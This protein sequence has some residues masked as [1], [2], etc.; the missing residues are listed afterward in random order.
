MQQI[1]RFLDS[2]A[3]RLGER[4]LLVL[5]IHLDEVVVEEALNVT[6]FAKGFQSRGVL[7]DG[8]H[9]CFGVWCGER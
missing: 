8:E 9:G 3:I 5:A 7:G 2:S 1:E 6:L 4:G